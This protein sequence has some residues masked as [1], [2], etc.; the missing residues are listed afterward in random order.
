MPVDG[1]RGKGVGH[2]TGGVVDQNVD[3]PEGILSGVEQADRGRRFPQV[4]FHRG[5]VAST[6]EDRR[7]DGLGVAAPAAPHFSITATPTYSQQST[8]TYQTRLSLSFN[9]SVFGIGPG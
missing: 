1:A 6:V 5:S 3:W 2:P 8:T 9:F 7:D 4:L